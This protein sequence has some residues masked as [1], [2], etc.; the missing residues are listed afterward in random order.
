MKKRNFTLVELLVAMAV[1]CIFVL[2]LIQ[3][4]GKTQ[5]V[6]TS[7]SAR[8]ELYASSR[9]VMDMIANDIQ[10]L[11]TDPTASN[12]VYMVAYVPNMSAD[13]SDAN[14]RLA[15]RRAEFPPGAQS[16]VASVSYDFYKDALSLKM[17]T[18]GDHSSHWHVSYDMGAGFLRRNTNNFVDFN[19]S[20]AVE[21]MDGV[22]DFSVDFFRY[23]SSDSSFESLEP[24]SDDDYISSREI[25]AAVKITMELIDQKTLE[26]I[27]GVLGVDTAGV[28]RSA[29]DGNEVATKL[30]ND[31][32]RAFTRIIPV[33]VF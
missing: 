14:L 32:K 15:T 4:F 27:A 18:Y 29:I 3:F 30:M 22:V 24:E 28:T 7:S 2:G 33:E 6:M 25:P 10:C 5:Q 12:A 31:N 23:N 19:P 17:T 8:N 13:N 20:D 1:L 26:R 9:V 11:Y 21:L 16:N